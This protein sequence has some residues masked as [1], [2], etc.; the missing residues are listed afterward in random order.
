MVS[1]TIVYSTVQA[2]PAM[3]T[4]IMDVSSN[5]SKTTF[6]PA[7]TGL[8]LCVCLLGRLFYFVPFS[9]IRGQ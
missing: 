3:S 4:E 2:G 9:S 6:Y 8:K 7:H 5:Y 1:T